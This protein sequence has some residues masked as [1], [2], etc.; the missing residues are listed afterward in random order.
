MTGS[1]AK[2]KKINGKYRYYPVIF[3]GTD[4]LGKKKYKWYP[5]WDTKKEAQKELRRILTEE[6]DGL[7][8]KKDYLSS[9]QTI[10]SLSIQWMSFK[11]KRLKK[12]T[13][14]GY[15]KYLDNHI[16]PYFGKTP[17]LEIKPLMIQR[18]YE[19]LEDK[20]TLR[21]V[22]KKLSPSSI[23][24]IHHIMSGMFKYA[25]RMQ[26]ISRNPTLY[27]EL[28]QKDEYVPTLPTADD[29][30]SILNYFI[31]T[32]FF[33]PI[34]IGSVLGLRRGEILGLPIKNFDYKNR[35]LKITQALIK[36]SINGGEILSTPKTKK[37]KRILL[38][39][40]YLCDII[41][42]H[43]KSIEKNRELF[44]QGYNE[45]NL[46][47]ITKEGQYLKPDSLTKQF[48]KAIRLLNLDDNI[49]LHDLRHYVATKLYSE[50][51]QT[52]TV[53]GILGHSTTSFT[54][55]TYVEFNIDNQ[56]DVTEALTSKLKKSRFRA[57]HKSL[58]LIDDQD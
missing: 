46:I 12:T 43:I 31:D 45:L 35:T 29:V 55:N 48:K 32:D 22:D 16:I 34:L 26:L 17:I 9:R 41:Q 52:K 44:G 7:D 40:D 39:D 57:R 13:L 54:E 10:K 20:D 15:Q 11:G 1:V 3:L 51:I 19:E 2:K 37:S 5:G 24:Q 25:M 56:M 50:G 8:S 21:P 58:A 6:Y 18:F 47:C 49:R 38:L 30:V 33:I 36:D 23:K 4:I 27:L 42:D 14:Y 28:P 53:S